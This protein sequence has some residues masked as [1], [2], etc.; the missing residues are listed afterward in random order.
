MLDKLEGRLQLICYLHA[1]WTIDRAWDTADT[2]HSA[3][4]RSHKCCAGPPDKRDIPG[5]WM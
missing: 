1:S 4:R 5:A 3:Q 2:W